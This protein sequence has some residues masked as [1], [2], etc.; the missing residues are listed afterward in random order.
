MGQ[1]TF[2]DLVKAD[3]KLPKNVKNLGNPLKFEARWQI[4]SRQHKIVHSFVCDKC[5]QFLTRQDDRQVWKV[6]T[7]LGGKFV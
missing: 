5:G 7:R 3:M 4:C 1:M 2:G 6:L